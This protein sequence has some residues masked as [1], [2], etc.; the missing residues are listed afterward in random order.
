MSRRGSAAIASLAPPVE[1]A[2]LLRLTHDKQNEASNHAVNHREILCLVISFSLATKKEILHQSVGA[3]R[4][5]TQTTHCARPA[6]HCI[7]ERSLKTFESSKHDDRNQ[8]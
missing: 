4:C 8:H 1:E 2:P 6:I 3:T 5:R 7:D